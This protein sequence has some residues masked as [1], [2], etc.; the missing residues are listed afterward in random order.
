MEH[1]TTPAIFLFTFATGVFR[2]ELIIFVGPIL[3]E[4]LISKRATFTKTIIVGLVSSIISLAISFAVDSF[5]WQRPLWPEGAVFW[6]NTYHNKSSDWGV[7]PY[8][9]Y[10]TSALPRA[11]IGSIAFVPLGL[12]F[13]WQRLKNYVIPTFVF[14]SL[15]SFLPHK[16]LRFIFYTIPIFN[17]V[18]AVGLSRMFTHREKTAYKLGLSLGV[19]LLLANI[20][21]SGFLLLVSSLNYPGGYALQK[22]HI[23]EENTR[24]VPYVHID[25]AAA[26]TG[27]SLYGEKIQGWRY[28]KAENLTLEDYQQFSH[29]LNGN[30]TINV[31]NFVLQ[32]A[33]EAYDGLQLSNSPKIIKLANKIFIW[34]NTQWKGT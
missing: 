22:L 32:G 18:A 26:Q 13:D 19:L 16:E 24:T 4:G 3:L 25:V 33:V 11:L 1:N 15:Y 28:S 21:M 29:L 7:S 12:Y 5:F 31:P 27:V 23:M 20:A 10:F 30:S 14:L 6:Y 17:L 8:H 9:W 2:S 34:K